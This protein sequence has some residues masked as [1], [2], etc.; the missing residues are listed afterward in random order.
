MSL[1]T[2]CTSCRT[3]FR[4]VQDQLKVSEGWVRCGRCGSVF[5]AFEELFDLGNADA[6]RLVAAAPA[7]GD[8]AENARHALAVGEVEAAGDT[9]ARPDTDGTDG[10][11]GADDSDARE[12]P[13]A[14][15]ARSDDW[16]LDLPEADGAAS[17]AGPGDA[18]PHDLTADEA[19][20]ARAATD[21]EIDQQLFRKRRGDD[22]PLRERDRLEFSDARFDSDL[23]ADAQAS[24]D[25]ATTVLE[26]RSTAAGDL[27]LESSSPHAPDFLRRADRKA[28]WRSRPMR[29]ALGVL[30]ALGLLTLALQAAHHWRDELAATQ[31]ALRPLLAAWCGLAGCTLQPPRQVDAVTVESTTLTRAIGRE[32]YVLVVTLQSRARHA[33]AM[34][35]LELALTDG[36]G[37]LLARKALAPRDFG[38]PAVLEPGRE[39]TLQLALDAGAARVSGYTVEIFHP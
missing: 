17:P 38:A 20:A 19:A 30:L 11:D 39:T 10:A 4:V 24:D 35:W 16:H 23:F 21:D 13:D 18:A 9:H 25:A 14:L 32:G 8:A 31:P 3:A 28:R 12:P 34:P 36:N 33:V 37:R 29:L 26:S 27:P 5:N 6:V 15:E 2:R 1:A 7:T 22:K